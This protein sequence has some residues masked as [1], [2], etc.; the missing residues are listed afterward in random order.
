MKRN[1]CEVFIDIILE[2]LKNNLPTSSIL[3]RQPYGSSYTT[4]CS[5]LSHITNNVFYDLL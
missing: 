3:P 5:K 4:L 2:V 1:C